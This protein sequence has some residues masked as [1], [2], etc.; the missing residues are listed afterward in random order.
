ME[1]KVGKEK[2]LVVL[3]VSGEIDAVT[4]DKLQEKID[5]LIEDGINCI[6]LDL[7]DVT[8]ISSAGLRVILGTAQKLYS[9][10]IFA[11]SRPKP[12]VQE[13]LEMVGLANIIKL[14]DSLESAK[15]EMTKRDG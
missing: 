11:V 9:N 1:I 3:Y 15:K 7:Y 12:N 5:E 2:D 8:Y 13:I 4:C 14:Y 10:G 6:L